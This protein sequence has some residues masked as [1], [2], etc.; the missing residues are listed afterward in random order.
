MRY[1]KRNTC[2]PHVFGVIISNASA[3]AGVTFVQ[4]LVEN[5]PLH[6]GSYILLITTPFRG[7]L[8]YQ[9]KI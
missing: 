2:G 9:K 6:L 1:E 8:A 4:L 3:S 7:D 5:P